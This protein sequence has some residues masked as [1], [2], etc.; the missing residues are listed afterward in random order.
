MRRIPTRA[1]CALVRFTA[2][3]LCVLLLPASARANPNVYRQALESTGWVLVPKTEKRSALGTC[4]VVDRARKLAV[5][6]Q[7]VVGDSHE[8]LVYFPCADKD[9]FRTEAGYYLRNVPAIN[10]R[11]L[12]TDAVRDLA[13][14]RLQ[15]LP[16][17]V[18]ELPLAEHSARPGET[19]HSIGNPDMGEALSEGT[20]WWYTRGTVRQV[21]RRRE[22]TPDGVRSVR[23]L[24]TQSPVNPGDSG[25]PVVNDDCRLVGV[26]RSYRADQRL[27]TESVDVLEVKNF[28]AE[29][30]TRKDRGEAVASLSGGWLVN[31]GDEGEEQ[32]HARAEFHDDGTFTLAPTE[33]GKP[34]R[35]GR[36]A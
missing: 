31:T 4:W 11:V 15:S 35:K 32:L 18:R 10:G 7:H 13:L 19:V 27:V 17:C 21:S 9:D 28:L 22:V 8:V 25:G 2:L 23:R 3:A 5:T 36:F 1:R 20:L 14:I 6:C 12:A 26:T 24:E 30:A 34:G 29:A 16:E 33:K